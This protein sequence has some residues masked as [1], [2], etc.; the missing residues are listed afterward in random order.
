MLTGYDALEV[1]SK[2]G[3]WED[4]WDAALS[5]GRPVWGVASTTATHRSKR[6]SA[7]TSASGIC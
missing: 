3:V 7:A 1:A 4:Y 6:A 2:Y 5:A